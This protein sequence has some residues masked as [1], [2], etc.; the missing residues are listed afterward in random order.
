MA[1]N[2]MHEIEATKGQSISEILTGLFDKH[3]TE[4]APQTAVAQELGISQGT[5]SL[6]LTKLRLVQKVVLIPEQPK[7]GDCNHSAS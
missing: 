5:L 7:G 1:S 3:G 2:K 6:W 4:A